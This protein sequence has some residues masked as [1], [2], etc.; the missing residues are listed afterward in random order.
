MNIKKGDTVVIVTGKDKGKEGKIVRSF[1][2]RMQVIVE[3]MNIKKKHQRARRQGQ[4]GQIVEFAA[5]MH[6]SNVSLKDPKTG[7]PTRTGVKM[8][9]KKKLRVAK[10]SGSIL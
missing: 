1:P 3:G 8:D 5:P 2:V 10:K 9:G 7:K 6:V 4:K